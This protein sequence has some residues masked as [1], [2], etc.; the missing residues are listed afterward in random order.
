MFAVIFL[1]LGCQLPAP[2][3]AAEQASA[4]A[5]SAQ[6][7]PPPLGEPQRVA[8]ARNGFV[9]DAGHD[10]SSF[11]AGYTELFKAHQ[12]VYITADSILHALHASFDHILAD[13]E[14]QALVAELAHWLDETRAGLRDSREGSAATRADLDL[15]LAVATSLLRGERAEPVAGADAGRLAAL[16]DQA[17]AA[18]GMSDIE[19]CGRSLSVDFS[20]LKPRGHYAA[21]PELSRYFAAMMWLG[22]IEIRVAERPEPQQEW[23]LN[24][25]ALEVAALMSRLSKGRADLAWR[26]IDEAMRA[27]IG[28]PDSMSFPGMRRALDRLGSPDL[29][30]LQSL[31]ERDIV[32]AIAGEAA[33]KIGTQP[34]PAG[35]GTIAFV[36]FG[37][38]YLFDSDVL[39]AVTYG[40]LPV[41]RMMPSP[42][43]VGAAVFH[44]RAATTLLK[45]ELARYQYRDALDAVARQGDQ[46]GAELWQGSM[47]H[48]WLAALRELS[49]DNKH[50]GKL[51]AF[52]RGQAWQRR[53]L[54]TQLASWAELRHDA[55]LYAK[56]SETAMPLCAFPN[57][58][59]DPYPG[60][61]AALERL[62]DRGSVLVGGL[63]LHDDQQ[64]QRLQH[65][66]AGLRA[67]AGQ[68]R[69]MA[70]LERNGKPLRKED[71]DFVNHAVSFEGQV[72]GCVQIM[73]PGGWY[74][75]LYYDRDDI[76]V[77]KPTI[78]DVHT[79]P[80][81]ETG[82]VVGKVLHVATAAP[83][84][85]V[86]TLPTCDGPRTFRGYVSS[87]YEHVSSH[88]QRFTDEEWAREAHKTAP[89][90]LSDIQ[91][92]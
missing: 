82:T 38:R 74:A 59:I 11:H 56:P 2:T 67:T 36:P 44:N 85:F 70:E 60:F 37:Q 89:L 41:K 75:D 21:T 84:A 39:S 91:P 92:Q 63:E 27:L 29:A 8:L 43:D 10:T 47:V 16:I 86:V 88:F 19:L 32:R 22:R 64:K 49:T 4:A 66:F 68:L 26:R 34:L 54:S 69:A 45:D 61:F 72:M 31:S 87:Y 65:Y 24:R 35:A 71:I 55:V 73:K 17:K 42:L 6:P 77:H 20:Q 1:T 51:P 52:M 53:L 76:R 13:L 12:P 90:W 58:F 5:A 78:A 15:Y 40:R 57:A 81:D 3:L 25:R 9:I 50:D 33:Q 62:A 14:R 46:M 23:R 7:H 28:P 30:R 18:A 79:Q 83:H 80:A 48:L